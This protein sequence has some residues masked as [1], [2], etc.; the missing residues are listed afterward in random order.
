MVRVTRFEHATTASQ[1]QSSTWLSY[2]RINLVEDRR[3]E[4]LTEACKATAFPITPI[5]RNFWTDTFTSSSIV[6][7]HT[8][9]RFIKSLYSYLVRLVR[10]ELTRLSTRASKTRM[11]TNY[12]TDAFF[13]DRPY[14]ICVFTYVYQVLAVLG[15]NDPHSYGVTSRRASMN[16]LRPIF[17]VVPGRHLQ[18]AS[19]FEK[20]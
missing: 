5:P 12:I 17:N 1:T 19:V 10:L 18:V 13:L 7:F 15:G 16:T 2:T 9:T 6:R 11:A 20:G 8:K 3:F 14:G 4:L